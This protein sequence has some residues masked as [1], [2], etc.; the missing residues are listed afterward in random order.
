MRIEDA[1]TWRGISVIA[2]LL[3]LTLTYRQRPALIAGPV[4]RKSAI[5]ALAGV[6]CFFTTIWATQMLVWRFGW[7][8]TAVL[9]TVLGFTYV[10]AGLW[11]RLHILRV[12]GFALLVISFCKLFAVDVWDFTAFMRVVSFI[13]LGAA[14]ILL[15]LFYNRFAVTIK[16]LLDDERGTKQ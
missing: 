5:A 12:C 9:W 8:P 3:A 2:A 16:A 10:S 11:Q 6:T 1:G 15:G 13:V 4:A 7:K 14:L